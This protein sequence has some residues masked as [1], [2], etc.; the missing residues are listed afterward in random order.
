MPQNVFFKPLKK[1]GPFAFAHMA[2]KPT[3]KQDEISVCFL[4]L[5]QVPSFCIEYLNF[6]PI[7]S[8]VSLFYF[9]CKILAYFLKSVY[10]FSFIF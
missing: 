1:S 6:A 3:Q 2:K 8:I 5:H 10:L 7:F 9:S 4:L